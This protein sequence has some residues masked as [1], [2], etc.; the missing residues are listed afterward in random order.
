[1][2][3]EKTD[4]EA[5]SAVAV[6]D[7]I[8]VRLP[9]ALTDPELRDAVGVGLYFLALGHRPKEAITGPGQPRRIKIESVEAK[10]FFREVLPD[11]KD[12]KEMIH[13]A[14]T[15]VLEAPSHV[16]RARI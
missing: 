13:A 9:H 11:F 7:S 4:L 14:L 5:G 3:E 1:M 2:L 10:R 6:P 16:R 15:L 8:Q 12:Q